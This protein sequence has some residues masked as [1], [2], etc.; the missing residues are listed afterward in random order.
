MKE[1][2]KKIKIQDIFLQIKIKINKIIQG[3]I[4]QI[5]I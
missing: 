1:Q 4:Q 5:K 2:F 3:I